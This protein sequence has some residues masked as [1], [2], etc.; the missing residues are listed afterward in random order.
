MSIL[1]TPLEPWARRIEGLGAI[2]RS[3]RRSAINAPVSETDGTLQSPTPAPA[4]SVT[5]P[6]ATAVPT[7]EDLGPRFQAFMRA[8]TRP[9]VFFD[10]EATGT[11]PVSDRIVEI[12]LLKVTPEGIEA[13][14]TWRVNPGV[15]IP[16]EA[17]E[18]HGIH[19][20]DLERAPSFDEIAE[21]L[22][23][24]LSGSDLAGFSI[25]RFDIRILH[26]EF[27]RAGRTLDFANTKVVDTQVIFHQREPRHLA[28]A[29]SFYREKELAGAH[30]AL[31]DTVASLEVLA[32][33]LERYDD[34]ACDVDG[35]HLVSS[36]HNDSYCDVARRFAWRDNEPVFNFGRLRGKS[37]RWAAGDP[38]ER[39]Y[40]KWFLEGTFEEDAKDIVREALRGRIR[41][42]PTAQAASN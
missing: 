41:R 2:E 24:V 10:I 35:L 21:D 11:D 5:E 26:A 28:A 12:S 19:N 13:P 34:L 3:L 30:G 20:E 23:T 16:A 32:G 1:E 22:E 6:P 14:R 4:P 42:R 25:G 37:L 9:I 18:I 31:A 15:R 33:Q 17:S 40:L 7:P 36:A 8:L 38:N 27:V 29:L 39:K